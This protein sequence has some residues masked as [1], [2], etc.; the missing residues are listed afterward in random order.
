MSGYAMR[1]AEV[2]LMVGL[3]GLLAAIA[4]VDLAVGSSAVLID[5]TGLFLNPLVRRTWAKRGRTPVLDS[6]GRHRDKVSVIGAGMKSHPGIAARTF[7]TLAELD[8]SSSPLS[9]T[10]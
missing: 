10:W 2:R 8:M 4:A 6:W 3:L 7:S 9:S 1:G 5:E